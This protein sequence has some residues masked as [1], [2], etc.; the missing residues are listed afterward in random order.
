MQTIILNECLVASVSP[1]AT[2]SAADQTRFGVARAV[3]IG[4]PKDFKDAY[5][6]QCSLW[7]PPRDEQLQAIEMDGYVG[8]VTE[9]VEAI[10]TA[11]VDMR[12]DWYAGEQ[13]ILQIR[14]ALWIALLHHGKLGGTVATVIESEAYEGLGFGY[15]QV[16]GIE[17][18]IYEARW[19]VRQQWMLSGGRAV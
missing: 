19:W 1:F 12:T 10:V 8:R 13:N 9:E 16:G 3:F 5:L 14:D 2:L 7:V 11:Y 18:R 6:P 17:Y 15:E 4:K